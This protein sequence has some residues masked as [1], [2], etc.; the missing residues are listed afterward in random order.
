MIRRTRIGETALSLITFLVLVVLIVYPIASI[1]VQSVLPGLFDTHP[2]LAPTMLNLRALV[3][4]HS[5]VQA[6]VNSAWMG[7]AVACGAGV[8]GV[9]LAFLVE[10][11]D[12]P[13]RRVVT[14]LVWLVFF[15]PSFVM[16]SSWLVLISTGGII[17]QVHRL[18]PTVANTFF[19][20][21][22]VIFILSLKLFPFVFLA[23]RA[24]LAG[25]GSEFSD[26]ARTLG[27][28]ALRA[29]LRIDLPLL[30]PALLAGTIIVFAE[31]VSDFGTVATIAQQ[32]GFPL[33]TYQ[34]YTSIN[35]APVNFPLSAAFALLLILI[36]A[37]A[38]L[39]Q[40]LLLRRRSYQVLSG[41]TRPARTVILGRW[42]GPALLFCLVAFTLAL[43]MPLIGAVL[44]STMIDA[45]NGFGVSNFTSQN[46]SDAL[47]VGSA[48]LG[49]LE[50]SVVLALIC[51]T[52]VS[53]AALPLAYT[54]ERGE[55]AGRQLLNVVTLT[56][57]A[58]PGIVLA[59][60]Y[61]FA[62]NQP[63]QAHHGF[64]F[65]GTIELLVVAMIA[66]ALPY[67]VRLYAGSL[68][69]V[70][71]TMIDASR[72]Q[73]AGIWTTLVLIVFPMLRAQV[74]SI[75]MLV[76]TGSM[77]ELAVAELLYP[78]GQPTMPIAILA[79]LNNF[80][81]GTAMALTLLSIAAL[82][83]VLLAARLLFWFAEVTFWNR[84]RAVRISLGLV[85]RNA[86][87]PNA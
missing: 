27:S 12:L 87:L 26:A 25:L 16:A 20:L 22:G 28:S 34:I 84:S 8:I 77:F 2:N 9:P 14:A 54:M 53:L 55:V 23:T 47:A 76:F 67:A 6:F 79:L 75:W 43:L 74:Q 36:I 48:N 78:P 61:I 39:L 52:V 56:A 19:S 10:R 70:N 29:S 62:W 68:A 85:R 11:T 42:K 44:T 1:V 65:Y 80:R 71:S 4:D 72:V 82:A 60:G 30:L 41:R 21:G 46:F 5:N 13:L 66:G 73:G 69:Q 50:R 83:G 31:A 35:T 3:A 38:M 58:V 59:A 40:A 7:V 51:A 81:T 32:S 24:G 64:Q 33:L 57:I 63:W 45:S 86:G 49:A 15:T 37:A 18:P 17:D